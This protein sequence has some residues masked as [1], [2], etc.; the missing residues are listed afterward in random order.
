[1]NERLK[2]RPTWSH[3]TSDGTYFGELKRCY[4]ASY[5]SVDNACLPCDIYSAALYPA[6]PLVLPPIR[7]KN[8]LKQPTHQQ[9]QQLARKQRRF[10]PVRSPWTQAYAMSFTTARSVHVTG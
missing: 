4:V 5:V 10:S 9:P 7:L 6:I 8:P 2:E 1:M 3:I